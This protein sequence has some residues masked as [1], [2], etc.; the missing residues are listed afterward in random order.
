VR[1]AVD[2]KALG[3]DPARVR[4]TA[5]PIAWFQEAREFAVGDTIPVEPGKGWLLRFEQR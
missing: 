1:L 4:I 5:P 2:W 3:L